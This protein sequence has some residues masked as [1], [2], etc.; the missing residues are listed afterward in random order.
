MVAIGIGIIGCGG[1]SGSGNGGGGGTCSNNCGITFIIENGFNFIEPTPQI[2]NI[3]DTFEIPSIGVN[4]NCQELD[5]WTDNEGIRYNPGDQYIV[6]KTDVKF[7]AVYKAARSFTEI[8]TPSQ[9]HNIRYELSKC[10]KLTTDIDL[11]GYSSGDGW[12]PIGIQSKPFIGLL[13]GNGKRIYGLEISRPSQNYVGLFGYIRG[14]KIFNLTVELGTNG[15]EGAENVGGIAGYAEGSSIDNVIFSNVKTDGGIVTSEAN[16]PSPI[17]VGGF[18]GAGS[19]VVFNEAINN[20]TV[21]TN[22]QRDSTAGGLAG[23]AYNILVMKSGNKESVSAYSV[24]GDSIAGGLIGNSGISAT[25]KTKIIQS[26]NEGNVSA[27]S[28]PRTDYPTDAVAG[29]IIGKLLNNNYSISEIS[30]SY[31]IGNVYASG[32]TVYIGGINGWAGAEYGGSDYEPDDGH[33]NLINLYNKGKITA[34]AYNTTIIAEGFV[35]GIA[36]YVYGGTLLNSYNEGNIE[37]TLNTPMDKDGAHSFIFTGGIVG[38]GAG[39]SE[40]EDLTIRNTYNI[41]NIEVK[42]LNKG[43]VGVGGVLGFS[44]KADVYLLNN[45]SASTLKLQNDSTDGKIGKIFGRSDGFGRNANTIFGT[46]FALDTMTITTTGTGT[47]TIE[48][49][50]LAGTPKSLDDLKNQSTY[51]TLGWKFGN[52]SEN[53]WKMGSTF[54]IL[55]YE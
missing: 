43:I 37:G 51:T 19:Y 21:S 48:T 47:T 1:G 22:T 24:T 55:Y 9:L 28:V 20:T 30:N 23:H 36:G 27:A 40:T 32:T 2:F 5:Y 10:Y 46:N 35:G 4:A 25:P 17:Y 42:A 33:T 18:I 34:N 41:G 54:P 29:G 52:D 39:G 16:K 44:Y 12:E 8:S 6:F 15:V 11:S 14:A 13:N 50:D 7:K 3:G 31:N 45:V 38:G 53:P 49:G 26:Y